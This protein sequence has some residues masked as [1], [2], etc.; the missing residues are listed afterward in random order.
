MQLVRIIH[1]RHFDPHLGRFQ[2]LAFRP[3]SQNAG[4]STFTADC[5]MDVSGAI[6]AHIAGYYPNVSGDPPIFWQF[7]SGILPAHHLLDATPSDTGDVCHRDILKLSRGEAERVFK[8]HGRFP[9]AFHICDQ[10][11]NHRPLTRPDLPDN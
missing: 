9:D 6:C 5:A 3:S 1:Q 10:N 2:S 4:I 7:D 8:D 11:G